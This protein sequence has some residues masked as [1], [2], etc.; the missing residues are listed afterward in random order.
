[1]SKYEMTCSC[2]HVQ[3][4][5]AASKEEAIKMVQDGMT[6]ES[7]KAHMAEKHPGEPVP[8]AEQAHASISQ[9]LKELAV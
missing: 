6:E 4:V 9:G 8:T 7:I 3:E 1:M 5:D 2:G